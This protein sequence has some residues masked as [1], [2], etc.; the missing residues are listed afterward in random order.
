MEDKI[1]CILQT[2]DLSW[3]TELLQWKRIKRYVVGFTN[4]LEWSIPLLAAQAEFFWQSYK[5][6]T[7][8]WRRNPRRK[9][10]VDIGTSTDSLKVAFK[11]KRR[12]K[13]DAIRDTLE[14]RDIY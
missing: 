13:Q 11:L 5:N 6:L 14:G 9:V 2:A 8:W 12:Y 3:F 4:N 1:A 10:L 7:I